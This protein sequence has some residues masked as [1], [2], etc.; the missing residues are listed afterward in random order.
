MP[1]YLE[2]KEQAEKLLAQAEQLFGALS[3]AGVATELVTYPREGHELVEPAHRRD[4]AAR[5]LRWLRAHG[6]L[7]EDQGQEQEWA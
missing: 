2:L 5:V 6:V 7:D 1:T 3:R 4:A